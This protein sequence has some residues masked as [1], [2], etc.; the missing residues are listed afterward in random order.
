MSQKEAEA[1]K[2]VKNHMW[3][4]MGAGLI[5]VPFVDLVA[6]SGVQ[7][8]MLS[9]ISKVYDL[10][11]QESR[12]KAVIGA[13]LGSV[14][15]SSMSFGVVGSML[16]A[17][18]LVGALVG[19]PSMAVFCGA[20]AW[21]LG[22]VFITHFEAGGTFLNFNPDQVKEHFRQVFEE[23]QKVAAT[24]DAEKTADVPVEA[25]IHGA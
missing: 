23:G 5:P 10:D 1:L 19:A 22:K 21:A 25:E 3:W 12:G 11:F 16:K 15:P 24:M 18:P 13:L 14:V 17:V 6:V 4:S 2:I 20:S 7:V 9:Q 8:R